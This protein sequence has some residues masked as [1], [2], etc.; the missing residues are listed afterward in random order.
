[1]LA[2]RI[3]KAWTSG[4]LGLALL[5][6]GAV[7]QAADI[8]DQAGFFSTEAVTKANQDIRDIEKKSGHEILIETHAAVP[9]A[10]VDA[11][12]NMDQKQR[13]QFYQNWVQERAKETKANGTVILITKEPGHI[14]VWSSRKLRDVGFNQTDHKRIKDAMVDGFRAKDY[15]GA[16]KDTVS[17]I[18]TAYS[19]VRRTSA[20]PAIQTENGLNDHAPV[21]AQHIPV[22]RAGMGWFPVI[23]IVG[24]VLFAMMII[25]VLSRLFSGGGRGYG[26]PA[27]PGYGQPGYGP[28]GY[29]PGP[30]YGGGGGGGFLQNMA[31]GLFGAVAG[32]WLYNAWG[33][34]SA[35]AHENYPTG[36]V[37]GGGLFGGGDNSQSDG[38]DFVSGGDFN[39]GGGG[40]G[41][42]GGGGG[43]FGGG[44]GDFGGGGDSGGG[45]DFS[46]GGDF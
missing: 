21:Q 3:H 45:G 40:G 22:R 38:G 42:F 18:G 19:K 2:Q 20:A 10:K 15:D 9:S 31:G 32:N 35:H 34:N 23:L 28:G 14:E 16:L 43:D 36:P 26:G 33:G 1:M 30:G 41:D 39:N 6:S 25:S 11:V 17:E 27:G 8:S 24:V 29:G 46:G 44:G 12:A 4:L 37:G 13:D 5:T 7:A